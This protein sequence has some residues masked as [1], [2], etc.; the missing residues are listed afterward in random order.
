MTV[1]F[2]RAYLTV[3]VLLSENVFDSTPA[4]DVTV[5]SNKASHWSTKLSGAN[6]HVTNY[7]LIKK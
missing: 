3:P 6:R 4:A 7:W 5:Q 2:G 1:L